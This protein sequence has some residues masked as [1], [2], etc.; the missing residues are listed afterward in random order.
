MADLMTP[1]EDWMARAQR[2]NRAPPELRSHEPHW[3][4]RMTNAVTDWWYGPNANAQQRSG[5]SHVIGPDS[6][7]NIVAPVRQAGTDIRSGV[8]NGDANDVARGVASLGM[9]ALPGS[10]RRPQPSASTVVN[11]FRGSRGAP[12]LSAGKVLS[13]DHPYWG[14]TSPDVANLYARNGSVTPF[15]AEFEKPYIHDAQGQPW[16]KLPVPKDF[17]GP[18]E[19]GWPYTQPETLARR[20]HAQGHDGLIINNIADHPTSIDPG[21]APLGS[22]VAALKRGTVRNRNGD[23]IYAV[24]PMAGF[25]GVSDREGR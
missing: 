20:A 16:S 8:S 19:D 1:P 13:E 24:P 21:V 4:D 17:I 14:S 22:T 18:L 12:M 23:L 9:M 25:Y 7:F 6:P 2:H 15:R 5:V 3:S 10:L 11:G